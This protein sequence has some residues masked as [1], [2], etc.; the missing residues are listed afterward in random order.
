MMMSFISQIRNRGFLE[1]LLFSYRFFNPNVENR[2]SSF[3]LRD[4]GLGFLILTLICVCFFILDFI[5]D[6]S[7]SFDQIDQQSLSLL[8]LIHFL[9]LIYCFFTLFLFFFNECITVASLV[10]TE[11]LCY[12]PPMNPLHCQLVSVFSSSLFG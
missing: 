3:T 10:P 6:Q 5:L 12:F 2:K 7:A 9:G 8:V 11:E 1:H 4:S